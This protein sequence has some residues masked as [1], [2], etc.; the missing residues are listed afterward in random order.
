MVNRASGKDTI[1][2]RHKA[3]QLPKDLE[4]DRL[5]ERRRCERKGF[6]ITSTGHA[7]V[8]AITERATPGANAVQQRRADLHALLTNLETQLARAG[9]T[10]QVAQR[11]MQHS[12]YRT[13]LKHYTVLGLAD[14]A[15]AIDR[16]PGIAAPSAS[17]QAT[18]TPDSTP[19]DP[20][21]YCQQLE[22]NREDNRAPW[23]TTNSRDADH[24][25][26]EKP[27]QM[28]GFSKDHAEIS[29]M[30]RRRLELPTP[31]LQS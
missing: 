12:H 19:N 26:N 1:H 23:R 30:E 5:I 21:Q 17:T 11:I 13:T 2:S 16:L 3:G 14:T 31:S 8:R 6:S 22:R 15:A 4:G 7:L 18:G 24:E 29:R 28:P 10:P 27:Q 9:V 25:T 20:Q